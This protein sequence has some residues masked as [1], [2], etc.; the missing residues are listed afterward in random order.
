MRNTLTG[1]GSALSGSSQY[2]Q[3]WCQYAALV[4]GSREMMNP[5]R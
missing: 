4:R 1:S 3:S 2:I 5:D